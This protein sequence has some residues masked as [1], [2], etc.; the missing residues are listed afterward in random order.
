VEPILSGSSWISRCAQ[1]RGGVQEIGTAGVERATATRWFETCHRTSFPA[2]TVFDAGGAF[3]RLI[4][5][6]R[7]SEIDQLSGG[8]VID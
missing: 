3:H 5:A 6:K 4:V 7:K 2:D 8:N 1:R